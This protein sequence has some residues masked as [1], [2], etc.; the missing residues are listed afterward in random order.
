MVLLAV[1]LDFRD[2]SSDELI[3]GPNF[4]FMASLGVKGS[5]RVFTILNELDLVWLLE[6]GIPTVFAVG[7][8][9]AGFLI[10]ICCLGLN[11]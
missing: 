10:E 2:T 6:L 7:T 4:C 8:C 5:S 1:P 3:T 9:L 11:F